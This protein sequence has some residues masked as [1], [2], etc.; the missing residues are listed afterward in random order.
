[1]RIRVNGD[2]WELR[3]RKKVIDDDRREVD[4]LCIHESRKILVRSH[5][6]PDD[7]LETIV[8]EL[9]HASD[10]RASEEAVTLQ[11]QEIATVLTRLGYKR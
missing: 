8:H 4:G 9:L 2:S 3:F 6:E 10:W 7:E 1:M 5:Q 11:A